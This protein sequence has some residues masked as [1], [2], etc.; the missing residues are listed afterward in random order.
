MGKLVFFLLISLSGFSQIEVGSLYEELPNDTIYPLSARSHSEI[1]P[2][3]RIE[4]KVNYKYSYKFINDSS[5]SYFI[6][7]PI[8]DAGLQFEKSVEYKTG[9]GLKITGKYKNKL[10]YTISGIQGIGKDD[11]KLFQPKSYIFHQK[12]KNRFIYTDL[13][14][15]FS[16]T[17]NKIF[18]FQTGVD[19]NFFGEGNRSLLLSDY[20]HPYPF[21]QIRANFGKIEYTMLYQLYREQTKENLWKEK[22][23]SAH[24][25]SFNPTNWL[26]FSFF[27]SVIFSPKDIG[28]FRGFDAEYLNPV[29]FFRPQE[30]SIGSSDNTFMGLLFSV[31]RKKHT[32]YGQTILDDFLVSEIIARRGYWS[33]KFGG[34]LGLK[35]RFNSN[36]QNFFYRVEFNFVRPY[37]YSHANTNENYGN[38][39]SPLA[40][41]YGSNFIE[42]IGEIKCQKDNF[43]YKFFGNYY[44]HGGDKNDGISYGGNIYASYNTYPKYYNNYIGQGV[45]ENGLN[46][47][48]SVACILDKATNLQF[49]VE[50]HFQ[51][52]TVISEKLFKFVIGFRSCLWNDYRNY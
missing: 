19:H 32:L 44:L 24:L 49:F 46:L 14:A 17:P 18:N 41:P 3:I 50:N 13:R 23:S 7:S 4:N 22:F 6:V 29:V 5:K 51:G 25:L 36:N 30:Y 39:N 47:I 37:T 42:L 38:Q 16:Y 21:A 11:S 43:I 40:H 45:K 8:I 34:Q 12:N 31:K 10:F 26:N 35:G 48:F 1:K 9:L 15:R 2:S 28:L 20:G 33:N 27:E 52:N